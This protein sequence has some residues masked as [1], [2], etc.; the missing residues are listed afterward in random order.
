MGGGE[1]GIVNDVETS[2]EESCP[3]G[4]D[5]IGLDLIE[6]PD[7]RS[8]TQRRVV[9]PASASESVPQAWSGLVDLVH[10]AAGRLCRTEAHV[11]DQDRFFRTALQQARDDA[12]LAEEHAHQAERL[13]QE[14]QRRAEDRIAIVE[15][16][17]QAAEERAR[18]AEA[19][20]RHAEDWSTR[21]QATILSEFPD[22]ADRVAA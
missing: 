16:R 3:G 1:K 9:P 18:I 13:A 21:V 15:A 5:L 4:A 12:V 11:R 10:A 7:E 8:D 14:A 19:R 2:P 20:A 22:A 17:V 6:T